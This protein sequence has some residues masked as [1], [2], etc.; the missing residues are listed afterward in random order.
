[1]SVLN[2]NNFGFDFESPAYRFGPL[3]TQANNCL[4]VPVVYGHARAAGN[5]IWQGSGSTTFNALVCFSEGTITG[6]SDIQINDIPITDPSLTGCTY[7]AYLGDGVQTIDSRVPGG[8]DADQAALVGGLTYTAYLALT[9]VASSKVANNYMNVSAV[10][11]GKAVN[12]YTTPTSYTTEYS[13][14]PAWCIL[15]FLTSYNGCGLSTSEIDIQSFIDAA[16][17]CGT[18]IN[19]VDATGTVSVTAGSPTV[20]GSGTLF[21]TEVIVDNQI[22]VNSESYTVIS[23]NSDTSLTVDANFI[24][25]ASDQTM[26]IKDTRFTLNLILDTRRTRQDWINEMLVCCRGYLA[27]NGNLISL[28]IDQGTTSSQTFT[29]D[30]ILP[31]SEIFWT[32]PIEQQCD[33]FKIRYQDPSN[34]Y[35]SAYAVAEA[36]T[37]LNDPPVIQEIVALGVTSFKQASRLAWFYL[38]QAN[39]CNQFFSFQT[40]QIGLNCTVGDVIELT[41]TFMG[42]VDMPLVIVAMNQAQNGQMQFICREYNSDLFGD[43]LGSVAPVINIVDINNVLGTPDD[44]ANFSAAQNLNSIVLTWQ[45]ISDPQATYEIHEG[46]SW[47]NASLVATGLMGSSYTVVNIQLGTYNYWIKAVNTYGNYSADATLATIVV[48]NIPET[49]TIINENILTDDL[50]AGTFVDCY[51]GLNQVCLDSIVNW[52]NTGTWEN[53][54]Q[55]YAPGGTW[56]AN[57]VT[58]GSYTSQ[59]YNIG[60]VTTAIISVNSNLYSMDPA[61]NLVIQWRYSSDDVTWSD[62]QVFTQGS[63]TFD[64]Y[65][66]SVTLNSPNN[67][68]TSLTSF[69]VSIVIP[70]R[71]LYFPDELITNASAG[72]T[73]TFS[74]AFVT[75]PAVVANISNGTSGYCVVSGKTTSQATIMAYNNSGTLITAQVDIRVKG[76]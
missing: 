17:Y 28:M 10:I 56:G 53:T 15:D 16:T 6:F 45:P 71:D 3:T 62:W 14:N 12:V 64:Y 55:Y 74:P 48:S 11:Q 61:S 31:D 38:N 67:F 73:V 70:N 63:Y 69:I 32:T 72:I 52:A 13:N 7:T 66:F 47:N 76:Y 22:T 37:F 40:T 58:T 8:T 1:M 25:S 44:V 23:V 59:V 19:P 2:I 75:V 35:A 27:Y 30:D 21:L 46:S 4:C 33:I 5:E 65:Q 26:V 34:Q 41:S 29:P 54:G 42:Y 24:S 9:I 20:T 18:M 68:F 36:D 51:A 49:N 39:T 60:S 50:S 57:C 43:T